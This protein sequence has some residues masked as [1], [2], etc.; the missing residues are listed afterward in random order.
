[1]FRLSESKCLKVITQRF[2]HYREKRLYGPMDKLDH[3]IK[4]KISLNP[5]FSMSCYFFNGLT[6]IGLK[7]WA[8][9]ETATQ[10]ILCAVQTLAHN[11]RHTQKTNSLSF[12]CYNFKYVRV[13]T[14]L[15][16][17]VPIK[18]LKT[19]DN[20]VMV[21]II[22]DSEMYGMCILILIK[23]GG[24]TGN[25]IFLWFKCAAFV[26]IGTGRLFDI[27][28]E[29]CSLLYHRNAFISGMKKLPLKS[30]E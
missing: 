4:N 15:L 25:I 8:V 27:Q 6:V 24:C 22:L 10:K 7:H 9:Y 20:V 29:S 14:G 23:W 17:L 2:C 16:T 28:L 21:N 18:S 3:Y 19:Q 30:D 11:A 5:S 1:M 12:T 13:F 26:L